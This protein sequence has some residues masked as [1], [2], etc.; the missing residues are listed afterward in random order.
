MSRS[1]RRMLIP[2]AVTVLA[3]WACAEIIGPTRGGLY[4]WRLFVPFDSLGP[5]IDSLTFHWPQSSLP[6]KYWVEDSLQAPAHVRAALERWKGA[7]LYREFDAVLVNDSNSA[8]VIVL[9][10]QPPVKPAPPGLRLRSMLPECEGATDID[11]V[12]TRHQFRIPARVY[13]NPRFF[14]N[15]L[16]ACME[17][18][19]THEIGHSLGLFVHSADPLD[20]MF[21][22]PSAQ[23]LSDLDVRTVEAIYH[24]LNEM[25]PTRP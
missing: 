25:V 19:A 2:A 22:D 12:A 16:A 7:F 3:A 23:R 14:T 13:L 5:R 21:A 10:L 17:I 6:V 9:V 20:V 4:E 1:R 11:T 8:D 18:T 24:L 15:A